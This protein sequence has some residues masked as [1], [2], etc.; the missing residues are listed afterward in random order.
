MSTHSL[1]SRLETV[2]AL[3]RLLE[4]VESGHV[5][6]HA[7]QYRQLVA[8]LQAA[9]SDE[10][11]TDALQAIVKAYPATGELY[12]NLHYQHAGLS[13]APLER[14]AASEIQVRELLARVASRPQGKH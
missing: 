8:Q 4:T 11:P 2:I 1:R 7:D 5:R 13:R 6:T 10:L 3:A 14:S 12:E 9:L